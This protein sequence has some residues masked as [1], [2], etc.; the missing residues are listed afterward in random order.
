M[1]YSCATCRRNLTIINN[2]E[3]NTIRNIQQRDIR[4][5]AN[6]D[7]EEED[8]LSLTIKELKDIYITYHLP[9]S[10][11]KSELIGHIFTH[12]SSLSKVEEEILFIEN[13]VEYENLKK[14]IIT[15]TD[16]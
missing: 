3:F 5:I 8:I 6:D 14:D 7:N 4:K 2:Y 9:Q 11:Q 13:K 1:P 16:T 10:G 12:L 15:D